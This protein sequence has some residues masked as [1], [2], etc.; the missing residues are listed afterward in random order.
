M[1]LPSERALAA[2][3]GQP[4]R[5]RATLKGLPAALGLDGTVADSGDELTSSLAEYLSVTGLPTRP[6][7]LTLTSRAMAGLRLV[8]DTV[9]P[10]GRLAIAETPSYPRA[11]RILRQRPP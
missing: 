9:G 7:Q 10:P 2:Q 8:L 4:G 1:R 6:A 3:P 11:P 5:L